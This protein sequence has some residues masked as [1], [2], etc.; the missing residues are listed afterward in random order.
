MARSPAAAAPRLDALL[1]WMD[2]LADPTRLRI[3]RVLEREELSVLELC[4]VLKLPQSTVSRHLKTLSDQGWLRN[5]REGTASLYRLADGIDAGAQRLWRLARAEADG[6]QAMEQ[7]GVRLER[8]RARRN[9]AE[10]FFAGAAAEWDRVRA[11]VYGTGFVPSVLRSLVP[12]EWTVADLGCGTGALALELAPSGARIVGVD[13]SAA[14]LRV[15]RRRTR[16][17]GNVELRQ[18]SLEAVPLPDRTCEAALLLF[19][20]SYVADVDAVLGEAFRILKPG[21]RLV[22]VDAFPHADESLRRRLGQTRPGLDP[23]WL[24]ER[25]AAAG[26]RGVAADG[27]I[28][29]RRKPSDPELFLARGVRP[30]ASAAARTKER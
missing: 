19:S 10:A 30:D 6:W 23:S 9:E 25:L 11:E 24:R 14:M 17:H 22:A 20:L 26:F 2:G 28:A 12:A 21:G 16:G 4:E 13:R 18:A 8:L 5:R 3:L 1:G 27:P 15:A 29:G 7:D